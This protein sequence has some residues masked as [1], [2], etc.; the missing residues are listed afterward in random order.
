MAAFSW[1]Q[2]TWYV[3]NF[4]TRGLESQTSGPLLGR[5]GQHVLRMIEMWNYETALHRPK[6]GKFTR[7]MLVARAHA[8]AWTGR[9]QTRSQGAAA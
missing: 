1:P 9:R 3:W 5:G 7:L 6:L 2:R 4:A 8:M